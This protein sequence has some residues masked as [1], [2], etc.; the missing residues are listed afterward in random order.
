MRVMDLSEDLYDCEGGELVVL[1]GTSG[2]TILLKKVEFGHK[3]K[4]EPAVMLV[5]SNDEVNRDTAEV[6]NERRKRIQQAISGFHFED[7]IDGTPFD[8]DVIDALRSIERKWCDG[9]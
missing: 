5:P 3:Y 7:P 2:K 4:E 6:Q 9:D 8:S 1:K